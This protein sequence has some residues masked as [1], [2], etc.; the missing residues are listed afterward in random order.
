M[1]KHRVQV[2]D[3]F[4]FPVEFSF[5]VEFDTET[6]E[7]EVVTDGRASS[8]PEHLR[9]RRVIRRSDPDYLDDQAYSQLLDDGVLQP[10]KEKE[11]VMLHGDE[12]VMTDPFLDEDEDTPTGDEIVECLIPDKP[13]RRR[14]KKATRRR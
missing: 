2:T 1:S 9:R 3:T 4:S 10:P 5:E 12:H 6:G 7:A 8:F 13:R 14:K 11:K